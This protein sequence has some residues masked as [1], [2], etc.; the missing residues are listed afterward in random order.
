MWDSFWSWLFHC[1][2]VQVV[3][4][5]KHVLLFLKTSKNIVYVFLLINWIQRT[6]HC[7]GLLWVSSWF[8]PLST[9][10][11]FTCSVLCVFVWS[12]PPPS[13][14]C[15]CLRTLNFAYLGFG[16][17]FSLVR[18]YLLPLAANTWAFATS[19]KLLNS[20]NFSPKLN[21]ECLWHNLENWNILLNFR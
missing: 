12:S 16:Y 21:L 4:K 2:L 7:S 3:W 17:C 8:P 10:M 20:V 18:I 11:C 19:N 1:M 6:C 15:L 5:Y 14:Y 13:V 9:L